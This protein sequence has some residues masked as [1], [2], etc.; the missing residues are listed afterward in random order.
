M[1]RRPAHSALTLIVTWNPKSFFAAPWNGSKALIQSGS[2]AGS[3]LHADVRIRA[4]RAARQ[5]RID[6]D[7]RLGLQP[8]FLD[9]PELRMP[10]A[11]ATVA[12]I[13]L[14]PWDRYLFHSY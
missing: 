10:L 2:R 7:L 5:G 11:Y 13:G 8:A 12:R 6:M 3:D 4:I 1:P 14:D 9:R